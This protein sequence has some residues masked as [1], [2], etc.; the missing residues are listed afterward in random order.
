[1]SGLNAKN[2]DSKIAEMKKKG[3]TVKWWRD[4]RSAVAK[5]SGVGKQLDT[6]LS[7]NYINAAGK[8]NEDTVRKAAVKDTYRGHFVDLKDCFLKAKGK[9]KGK[10]FAE[11]K[12]LCE[13]YIKEVDRMLREIDTIFQAMAGGNNPPNNPPADHGNQDGGAQASQAYVKAVKEAFDEARK[14][15]QIAEQL[16]KTDIPKTKSAFDLALQK[17]QQDKNFDLTGFAKKVML[18]LNP[19]LKDLNTIRRIFK[20]CDKKIATEKPNAGQV[21]PVVTRQEQE[22][23][24]ITA[25]VRARIDTEM[26]KIEMWAKDL[27]QASNGVAPAPNKPAE[28]TALPQELRTAINDVRVIES[29]VAEALIERN[30]LRKEI[31][32]IKSG[33]INRE[34]AIPKAAEVKR[35]E[36]I[37]DALEKLRTT[38]LKRYDALEDLDVEIEL[39]DLQEPTRSK[40][41]SEIK[42][43]TRKKDEIRTESYDLATYARTLIDAIKTDIDE[44]KTQVSDVPEQGPEGSENDMREWLAKSNELVVNVQNLGRDSKLTEDAVNE[45]FQELQRLDG[46]DAAAE[47]KCEP[48]EQLDA[49]FKDLGREL[50]GHFK[51]MKLAMPKNL[52]AWPDAARKAC[53]RN[54]REVSTGL[55]EVNKRLQHLNT[56]LNQDMPR[57]IEVRRKKWQAP[58]GVD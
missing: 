50:K 37:V 39:D 5:G 28:D 43:L 35:A 47:Q 40:A 46:L 48:L 33:I 38:S 57:A 41:K 16:I 58:E 7:W 30:K 32:G 3:F 36:E 17:Y 19:Q 56:F 9:C 1:M 51:A 10:G 18:K 14:A 11:S 54:L 53:A 45:T 49:R 2:I 27:V 6:M 15:A 23:N 52:A 29:A 4:H 8:V 22:Y 44:W 31:E 12:K 55:E 13:A 20:D 25:L 21:D 26:P 42:K 34:G 24:K